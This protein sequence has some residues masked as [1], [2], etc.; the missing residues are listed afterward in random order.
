MPAID[1]GLVHRVLKRCRVDLEEHTVFL[2]WHVGLRRNVQY[3]A[4]DPRHDLNNVASD[5]GSF[6]NRSPPTKQNAA[7]Y[8]QMLATIA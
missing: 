1:P 5:N 4:F 8:A 2:Q 6:R 7:A 3:L